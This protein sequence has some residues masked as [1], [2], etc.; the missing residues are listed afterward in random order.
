MVSYFRTTDVRFY[1][2]PSNVCQVRELVLKLCLNPRQGDER[3]SVNKF[4][5]RIPAR[6]VSLKKLKMLIKFGSHGE[7]VHILLL[8]SQ[9]SGRIPLS[10]RL[11]V[12]DFLLSVPSNTIQWPSNLPLLGQGSLKQISS[13]MIWSLSRRQWPAKR[14]LRRGT[15][16]EIGGMSPYIPSFVLCSCQEMFCTLIRSR[17]CTINGSCRPFFR[18]GSMVHILSF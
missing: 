17:V 15:V 10:S 14:T 11:K 18:T 9:S 5:L 4:T 8:S 13:E 1:G 12:L 6:N 7:Y 16:I 2:F 3:L